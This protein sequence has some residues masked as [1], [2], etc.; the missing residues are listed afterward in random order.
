MPRPLLL[1]SVFLVSFLIWSLWLLPAAPVISKLDGV[2]VGGAPLQMSQVQGRLW[3]GSAHWRWQRQNGRLRWD[4]DWRGLTPGVQLALESGSVALD[5][6]L[7]GGSG[8][9]SARELTLHMP[10]AEIARHLEQGSAEGSVS[11]DIR[12]LDWRDDAFHALEGRLKWSGGRVSWEPAGSAEV[13][14][15]DGRLFMEGEAARAEVTDPEGQQLA[16]ARIVDGEITFRVFRAW[17]MLLGVS[18]GGQA[19]DVVLEVSQ[20]FPGIEGQ[21]Q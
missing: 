18:G 2:A 10:V 4:M 16:E 19:S 5:G 8:R 15:L 9:F 6:W 1:V 13:P 3:D 20:P 12:E 21:G 14:P 7:G 11:A 17:P